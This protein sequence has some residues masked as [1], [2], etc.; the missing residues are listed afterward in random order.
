MLYEVITDLT[1]TKTTDN[2]Q[3]YDSDNERP[4][5]IKETL[6]NIQEQLNDAIQNLKVEIANTASNTGITSRQKQSIG[7]RI[8]DPEATSSSTSL[9]GV[10]QII[11][12]NVSQIELDI[13]GA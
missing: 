6:G 7:A 12:K 10:Q 13:Y 8:F 2:G 3:Y 11:D 4:Y 1:S 9:D 5:T